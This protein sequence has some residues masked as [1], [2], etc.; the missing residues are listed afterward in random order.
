VKRLPFICY[1]HLLRLVLVVYSTPTV[2]FRTLGCNHPLSC[3][4][5]SG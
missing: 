3:L 5:P 2:G 1:Y 4:F